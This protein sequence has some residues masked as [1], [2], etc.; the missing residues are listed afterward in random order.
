MYLLLGFL[1]NGVKVGLART[2]Q[3]YE[4]LP[5]SSGALIYATMSRLML[6]RLTQQSVRE[7]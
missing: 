7:R 4:Y 2:L 6:R 1:Q 3:K 5:A